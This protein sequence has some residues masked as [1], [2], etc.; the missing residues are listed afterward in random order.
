M[1]KIKLGCQRI[2]IDVPP[3][4][5][6][7]KAWLV[8]RANKDGRSLSNYIVRILEIYW[9]EREGED[10]RAAEIKRHMKQNDI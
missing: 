8:E 7:L 5:P 1:S 2:T 9:T 10:P 6:D 4:Y 3:E